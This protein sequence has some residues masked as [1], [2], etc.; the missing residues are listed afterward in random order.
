VAP[1]G[2]V[3][4]FGV[5]DRAMPKGGDVHVPLARAVDPLGNP[6][7]R[8]ARSRKV[9]KGEDTSFETPDATWVARRVDGAPVGAGD[10]PTANTR[11]TDGDVAVRFSAFGLFD[12]HGGK[13][14]AEHCAA[15]MLDRIVRALDAPGP[16]PAG[17]D[18][19]DAFEARLPA[20]LR[21]AFAACDAE[22]LA[23]D[24]HSGAT[25]TVV[26]VHGRCVTTASVGDSL[27]VLDLGVTTGAAAPAARLS[28]EH[29]L[30][31]SAAERERIVAAGGEVRATAFE[32]GQPVGPLRVWPGGLAVSRTVGDRDGKKGG[33]VS[34]PEVSRVVVPDE[35]PGF[36]ITLASDGLWD[37]VTVKQAAQ[38]AGRLATAAAAAALCKRAQKQKDNRD[39]ITV[40]VVDA[41]A[42]PAHKDPFQEKPPWKVAFKVKWPLRGA[43]G[44]E[45]VLDDPVEVPPPSAR[46]RWRLEAGARE[47]AAAAAA[48]AEARERAEALEAARRADARSAPRGVPDGA[49]EAALNDGGGW[50][51]VPSS[52]ARSAAATPLASPEKKKKK[53]PPP[54][55]NAR[56]VEREKRG[57][58]S[59]REASRD[60]KLF[61]KKPPRDERAGRGTLQTDPHTKER[62][63]A[64]AAARGGGVALSAASAAAAAAVGMRN[65]SVSGAAAS[66]SAPRPS[67]EQAPATPAKK[68]KRKGK[69]E[70]AAERAAAEAAAARCSGSISSHEYVVATSAGP[71]HVPVASAVSGEAAARAQMAAQMARLAELQR[72]QM[73]LQ[74][75]M[76]MAQSGFA[77]PQTHA[78]RHVSAGHFQPAQFRGNPGGVPEEAPSRPSDHT[79][80]A[81]AQAPGFAPGQHPGW[82]PGGPP[83]FHSPPPAPDFDPRRPF[84]GDA[85]S[86]SGAV[87]GDAPALRS[88]PAP[89]APAAAA[90]AS[91]KAKPKRKGKRERA[92]ERAR[93]EAEAANA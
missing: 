65:L 21:D 75:Q 25:A 49:D 92:Q 71:E 4:G 61:E 18:A 16:V 22:F 35:Q 3:R 91:A 63:G 56:S 60:E 52:G 46:A 84:Q 23:K 93:R 20:A 37:A 76:G 41:L 40:L 85:R 15:T 90:D 14:C 50:E 5:F 82:P 29:R 11:V 28:P 6:A 53:K 48:A 17:A 86:V 7:L 62:G 59:V 83:P 8:T 13:A 70:R 31:T 55:S 88:A 87:A 42:D 73:E 80:S 72:Q 19:D 12:G 51:E 69:R 26:V 44:K 64:N 2:R 57:A 39:D 45:P 66:F 74:A 10:G 36:R 1:I 43:P 24:V 47:A 67:A 77:P 30:D 33:V 9:Q 78:A 58:G 79:Q 38:C 54:P 81:Y 34:E 68:E 27:A 89:P 32:D